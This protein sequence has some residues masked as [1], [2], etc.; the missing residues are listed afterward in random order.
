MMKYIAV[1]FFL[2]LLPTCALAQGGNFGDLEA[3]IPGID[4]S[5]NALVNNDAP[6]TT[7]LGI[8]VNIITALIVIAGLIMIVIGGYIY[9]TAGGSAERVGMA[10]TFIGSA[11][12]GI[13]LALAAVAILN[14]I[15]PN[16]GENL[17]EPN[18]GT[19]DNAPAGGGQ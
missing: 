6:F 14:V 18:F 7:Y 19:I 9:M 15:N 3:P 11:L 2:F 13:V 12:L 4:R 17:N 16:I 1:I 5:I 10:K 8:V